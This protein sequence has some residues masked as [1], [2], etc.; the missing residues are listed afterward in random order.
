MLQT[1]YLLA[2]DPMM[3]K[4]FTTEFIHRYS[5]V[6]KDIIR[7]N[8]HSVFY[9]GNRKKTLIINEDVRQLRRII[10]KVFEVE[11]NAF[12]RNMIKGLLNG[13]SSTAIMMAMHMAKN[14][15]IERKHRFEDKVF[16]YCIYHGLV[17]IEELEQVPI[18]E[19]NNSKNAN[20]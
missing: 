14:A 15:F 8:N 4:E 16:M 1:V 18:F 5:Y 7:G 20:L 13:K 12:V 9:V 11:E 17:T 10:I 19:R 3:N 2:E 6:V